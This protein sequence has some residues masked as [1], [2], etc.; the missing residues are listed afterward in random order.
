ME[1]D[2]ASFRLEYRVTN[3]SNEEM[4][5]KT[6]GGLNYIIRKSKQLVGGSGSRKV[7]IKLCNVRFQDLWLDPASART[8]F[9]QHV[10]ST[11][12]AER[13]HIQEH[14]TFGFDRFS[15]DI[16]V[17]VNLTRDL[18]DENDAIHSDILGVTFFGSPEQAG[19]SPID[20]PDYTLAELFDVETDEHQ[21]PKGGLHYFIHLN[22]PMS[23]QQPYYTNVMGKAVQVPIVN[24]PEIQP[25]LYVGLSYSNVP[26]TKLYYPFAQVDK[27]TLDFLGL[28]KTRADCELG[29]NTERYLA[30]ESRL[31][32]TQTQLNKTQSEYESVVNLLEKAQEKAAD[33]D[34]EL[35][36]LRRDH[37]YEIQTLKQD[38]R[39]ELSKLQFTSDTNKAKS[40]I[41]RSIIKASADLT[42]QRSSANNW[43]EIA[44][45]AGAIATVL[46]TGYQLCTS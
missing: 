11:I 25:G 45:A 6:R 39:M 41:D 7:F 14:Q 1:S 44:K 27:E 33:L 40:E 22:D 30:A 46:F 24:N 19:Y 8:R 35:S 23:T 13:D 10:M 9:D 20:T 29:G 31:K 3:F 12:Q 17:T 4:V 37:R 34:D 32:T 38:H 42:K 43:G 2:V 28:F 36:Q 26:P 16:N 5:V 18:A 21:A 15:H